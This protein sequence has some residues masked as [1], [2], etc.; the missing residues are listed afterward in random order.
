MFLATKTIL[1]V[2]TIPRVE[3]DFMNKTHFE[4]IEMVKNLGTLITA[5]QEKD[6]QTDNE[7]KQIEQGLNNWL[8]HTKLHFKRENELMQETG[9]PAFPI[10]SGEH[11]IA[12]NKMKTVVQA[13]E[14]SNDI[15]LVA[16]YVFN[17]WPTWFNAHV[18][19]MDMMTAKFAVMNGFNPQQ[20]MENS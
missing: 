1:D 7:I 17:L 15:E 18:N 13:W 20:S 6:T 8:E 3:I 19:S 5:F 4:E 12:L 11:E 16:D 2:A 9:F 10:H 14:Q